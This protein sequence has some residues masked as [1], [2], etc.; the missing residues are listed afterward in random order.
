MIKKICYLDEDGRFGGPQQ[1][2]IMIAKEVIK[3]D[4]FEIKFLIPKNDTK[5]FRKKLNEYNL[6][7][8]EKNITRLS[9]EFKILIKYFFFFIFE[10]FTIRNYLKNEKFH[11][12]QINSTSQFKGII[13][14]LF[15]NIKRIWVIE[16]TNLGY[17]TKVIFLFLSNVS[18]CKIIY[19]SKAVKNYYLK[20]QNLRNY[21]KEIFAPVDP[22]IFNPKKRYKK[23][24]FKKKGNILITTISGIVPVKGVE[25]FIYVVSNIIKNYDNVQFLFVG[26]VVSSQKTYSKKIFKLFKSLDKNKFKFMS[27][28][29]NIP[30][31]LSNSDIFICTSIS[32]AGPMT[33][34]EAI[35]LNVPIIT[36]NVG[37]V[38]QILQN[39]KTAYICKP[40]DNVGLV[41]ATK[42][43][44]NLFVQFKK[45]NINLHKRIKKFD[46]LY[47]ANEYKKI[48]N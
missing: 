38:P 47:V 13:A 46:L 6:S 20:N 26:D 31:L 48:Y 15:L 17:L 9:L 23:L 4:E 28:N 7:Y 19:T 25:S 39:N 44:I 10:I 24:A 40:N 2:M 45:K 1:R 36:T 37:G 12:L 42:K 34:Y 33:V 27:I 18:K 43:M 41:K 16:D 11:I 14:S 22:R 35:T 5:F 29:R 32:E 8:D 21:Q 3:D 30:Q